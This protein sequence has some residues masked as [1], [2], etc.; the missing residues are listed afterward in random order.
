MTTIACKDGIMA[1]DSYC[2]YGD[3]IVSTNQTKIFNIEGV[4]YGFCGTTSD[5]VRVVKYLSNGLCEDA[6]EINLS[7]NFVEYLKYNPTIKQLNWCFIYK[8]CFV[9]EQ[10]IETSFMAIGNGMNFAIA[11]MRA[12]CSAEESVKI[13][14]E[15]DVYSG[16]EVNSIGEHQ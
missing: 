8:D 12:G 11:A 2:T 15:Y 5:I 10:L 3:T 4:V 9:E 13:A 6:K 7:G 1:A 14:C 16:G